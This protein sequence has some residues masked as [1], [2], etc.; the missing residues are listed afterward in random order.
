MI[1]KVAAGHKTE[2]HHGATPRRP[3]LDLDD[4]SL[5][6]NTN[7]GPLTALSNLHFGVAEGE[8]VSVLGPS[9]CGKSTLL[10]ILSG[11][12]L[13]S[14]GEARLSGTAI[15]QPSGDVGVVFQKP[16]LM[17]W[18]SVLK[19]V[20]IC[21]EA[22]HM[23]SA[24]ARRRAAEL[25]KMV[26]LN[27]FEQNYPRE[28]SGGMQQRVALVRG[29]VHDPKILLMDEPFSAL[30]AMTRERMG[31]ELQQLWLETQKS[32]VFI[33]HSIPEAA[34]LS[35]RVVVLSGRPGRVIADIP[36]AIPRPRSL[37]T[38]SDPRFLEICDRLRGY[39][40]HELDGTA[41]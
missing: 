14:S 7:T 39:F 25:L 19:N 18:R 29:L 35:D 32:V 36:V 17:P 12:V 26:G 6:Y 41:R 27:G 1:L 30:D 5:V 10:K 40:T 28:L 38:M 34:F 16:N 21:A 37:E 31:I 15:T 11:L 23:D 4:I 9:G 3:L 33:T 24:L 2:V 8:F 20:L 13:P 22:L